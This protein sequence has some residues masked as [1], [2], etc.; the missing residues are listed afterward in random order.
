MTAPRAFI[1]Y[2]HD[3]PAHKAWT[4]KLAT[5][6]RAKGVDVVLD[7]WDLTPGQDISLF[8]QKGISEADRVLM[9]CS[10]NYVEKAETGIGGV[11]SER[12]IARV[13]YVASSAARR[14]RISIHGQNRF[15]GARL[16]QT[17]KIAP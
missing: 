5:D 1:S 12:L 6:L 4:L 17:L 3:S 2:S 9:I 15:D 13:R 7:Q 14:R 16:R 8:M 11:G 10:A